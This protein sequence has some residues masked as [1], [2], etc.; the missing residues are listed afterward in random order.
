VRL[1]LLAGASQSIGDDGAAAAP[2]ARWIFGDVAWLGWEAKS[3][4]TSDEVPVDTVR[5]TNGHLRYIAGDRVLAI[6]SG[7][8][9]VLTTPQEQVHPTAMALAEDHTVKVPLTFPLEL[10]TELERAWR[11]IRTQVAPDAETA[12]AKQVMYAA[13]H[14]RGVLPTQVIA[15]LAACRLRTSTDDL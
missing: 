4:A 5:Q 11:T 6:P 13:F 14:A 1:G 7:S 15:R 9:A 2:D 12:Q 3:E 10:A 8:L